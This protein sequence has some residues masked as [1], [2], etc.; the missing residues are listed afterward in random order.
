MTDWKAKGHQVWRLG[1][2]K[3][4]DRLPWV[5]EAELSN[6]QVW[7]IYIDSH[8]GDAFRHSLIGPE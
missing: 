3:F 5:M 7:N 8:T 1:M 4:G 2:K 6:V